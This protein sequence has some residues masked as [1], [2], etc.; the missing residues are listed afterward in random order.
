MSDTPSTKD[1][2]VALT[3]AM[4]LDQLDAVCLGRTPEQ[5]LRKAGNEGR[6]LR[7]TVGSNYVST[8][9]TADLMC[10]ADVIEAARQEVENG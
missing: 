5:S 6:P 7:S 2:S 9:V 3:V 8:H 4:L 10:M 1:G